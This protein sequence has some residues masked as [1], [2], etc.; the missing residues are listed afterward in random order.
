MTAITTVARAIHVQAHLPR[1]TSLILAATGTYRSRLSLVQGCDRHLGTGFFEEF[2]DAQLQRVCSGSSITARKSRALYARS[3]PD[4]PECDFRYL[5][6]HF[7]R[8]LIHRLRSGNANARSCLPATSG[9]EHGSGLCARLWEI[10]GGG[11]QNYNRFSRS[12][13]LTAA[14]IQLLP[15]VHAER[16]VC[17][18][19]GS[20]QVRGRTL[21]FSQLLW[22][23]GQ[24]Q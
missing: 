13:T 21:G 23:Q 18:Y 7:R 5:W 14:D 6:K 11:W 12:T 16:T 9:D 1:T 17:G 19:R 24:G 15:E 3:D 4:N 8:P 22:E 2:N 10:G 20:V